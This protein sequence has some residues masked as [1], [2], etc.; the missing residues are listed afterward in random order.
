[1]LVGVDIGGTKVDV[2]H[3]ARRDDALVVKTVSRYSS[4]DFP[5]LSTLLSAKDALK[6]VKAIGIGVAGPVIGRHAR[7][8]NLAWEI[9]A[10][11]LERELGVPVALVNDLE[12]FGYG[13][14]HVGDD[15]LVTLRAGKPRV[16]NCALIAAGTGLGEAIVFWDGKRHIPSASEGGHADFAPRTDDE[17]ELL[18]F[19]LQRYER[20]SWERVASGLDGFRNLY[21]FMLASGRIEVSTSTQVAFAKQHDIG[22]ALA[23]AEERGEPFAKEIMAWFMRLYGAEAGNLALKALSVGGMYIAG[24][25]AQKHTARLLDGEFLEAFSSKGR[26]QEMLEEMPVHVVTD[27]HAALKG[28]AAAAVRYAEV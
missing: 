12:A 3:I 20:V 10:V 13:L 2:A 26:F 11:E 9:D 25:I 17:I 23:E 22:V 4:A 28:A 15:G 16:G 21:D 19:L 24:G 14:A 27:P 1:M 7:L 18:K 6:G 8:T 5:D